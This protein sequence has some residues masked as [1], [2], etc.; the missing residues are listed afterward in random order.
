MKTKPIHRDQ[1]ADLIFLSAI[2]FGVFM[3]FNP[4]LLAGFPIKQGGMFAVMADDLRSNHYLLPVYTTY[5]HQDIPFAYPPLGFYAGAIVADVFSMDS[6]QVL[7]WL[8]AFFASL[9]IPAFYLLALRVLK[10]KYYA[11]VSTLFFALMPRALSWYVTGSGLTRSPGQFFFLLTLAAAVRLYQE[12]RRRD[13]FWAGIFAGLTVLSHPE[14]ALHMIATVIFLWA[15]L[16]HSRHSFIQSVG[17]GMVAFLITSP[18]WITILHYHGIEPLIHAAQTGQKSA[19]V[20]N[21]LFFDFTEEPYAKLIAVLG[22]IGVANRLIRRDYLLPLWIAIPF[23]VE[24]RSA[25]LPAAIPLAMLAAV[26]LV[27]VVLKG[28]LP[29]FGKE[30]EHPERVSGI[31]F[32]I[33]IYVLFYLVFS[34]YQFGSQLSRSSVSLADQDAMNWIRENTSDGS[35]FLVLTGTNSISCDVVLEWFPALSDRQ[36]LFTVQGTEW[37][38]G[39]DFIPYVRSTYAVQQCLSDG[40][41]SC[42]DSVV[43]RSE[44]DFVYVSK[45]PRQDCTPVNFPNAFSYFLQSIRMDKDF[46]QLYESHEVIIFRK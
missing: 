26:G 45:I 9:S 37:T 22:L 34:T 1:W 8:P 2:L 15:M 35:R 36:S 23:L 42:L 25:I 44:Y 24:G 33:L 27:D 38:K 32:G 10:N 6:S 16:G 14:A 18:W 3:R 5:N 12:N 21:L 13:I 4:T 29:D 43:E 28:L 19:A 11:S 31:E 20:L 7:R 40:E 39:A 17:V 46:E 41:V 30:T